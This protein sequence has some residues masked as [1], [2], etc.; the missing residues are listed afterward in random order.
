MPSDTRKPASPEA[1][2]PAMVESWVEPAISASVNTII[3]MAGSASEAII[4]SRL[5][6]MPPKLVPTSR[7]ASAR[8]KRASPS[9]AMMTMRSA[10]QE[11]IRPVPKVGTN[12]AATQVAA[13]IR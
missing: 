6:P 3:S 13:K 9:S 1:R 10:D 7:P 8:K 5:E 2:K 11:N 4:T 12:A